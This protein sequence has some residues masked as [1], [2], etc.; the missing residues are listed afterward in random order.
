MGN[1]VDGIQRPLRVRNSR[2]T[3]LS[4]LTISHPS[5]SKSCLSQSIS[6]AASTRMHWTGHTSGISPPS[7][8]RLET[9]SPGET[10]SAAFM[11]TRSSIATRLCFPLAR[12]V[13]SP[14]SPRKEVTRLMWVR[15]ILP[16]NQ[17]IDPRARMW[18]WKPSLK[19]KLPSIP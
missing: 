5:L 18:F 11:K 15:L 9:M 13:R 16:P 1:I 4:S 19:G 8:S 2:R 3:P 7:I 14:T 6:P 12:W 17:L 10:Y